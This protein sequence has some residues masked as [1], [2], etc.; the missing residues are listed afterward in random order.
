MTT[1]RDVTGASALSHSDQVVAT[2]ERILERSS[3][4]RRFIKV[5]S[6][7]LVHVIEAGDGAPV[8]FLHG[9]STSSMLLLPLLERLDGVWGI[10]IDRPGFGLS[11]AAD[12]PRE[13]FRESAI[14][15]LD[16][17]LER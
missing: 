10:G 13:R 6:D 8:V 16:G 5:G 9:S 11:D 3:A 2:Y 7:R 14:E 12:I 1:E 4:N 15:W 17:V